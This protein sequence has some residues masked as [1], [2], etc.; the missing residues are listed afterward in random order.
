M[1]V[2]CFIKN[3]DLHIMGNNNLKAGGAKII[4][5]FDHRIVMSFYIANMICSKNNIIINKSCVKTSYPQFFK[6][7]N[8]LI[9]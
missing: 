8:T 3:Y 2:D 1:G 7:F 9:K 6:D 5:N 4:H